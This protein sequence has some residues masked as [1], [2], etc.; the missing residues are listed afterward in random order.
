MNLS[1]ISLVVCLLTGY[2]H[3]SSHKSRHLAP[4]I[5]KSAHRYHITPPTILAIMYRESRFTHSICSHTDDIGIMQLHCPPYTTGPTCNRCNVKKLTCNIDRGTRLLAIKKRRWQYKYKHPYHW[6]QHNNYYS[7]N[8][9]KK[10]YEKIRG[11][12]DYAKLYCH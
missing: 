7:K 3:Q 12:L 4:L 10:V 9:Y 11:S 6:I 2:Y 8:Y 1:C 5:C